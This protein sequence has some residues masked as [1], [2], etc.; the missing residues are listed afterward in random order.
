MRL[1]SKIDSYIQDVCRSINEKSNATI[2]Y[3]KYVI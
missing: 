1:S 2:P 3:E